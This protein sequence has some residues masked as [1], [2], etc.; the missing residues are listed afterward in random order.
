MSIFCGKTKIPIGSKVRIVK[1]FGNECEPFLNCT[2]VAT[3]PFK[4]GCIKENWIGVI[5]DENTI[6]GNKLNFRTEE[7]EIYAKSNQF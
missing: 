2:G 3:H 6:Y 5:L 1:N 7:I 4:K